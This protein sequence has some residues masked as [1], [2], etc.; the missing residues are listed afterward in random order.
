MSDGPDRVTFTWL[1]AGPGQRLPDI[2]A[3]GWKNKTASPCDLSKVFAVLAVDDEPDARDV[4]QT[5]LSGEGAVVTVAA[6]AGE[7][8]HQLQGEPLEPVLLADI[9]M[10]DEDGLALIQATGG[11][12]GRATTT[13]WIER[14]G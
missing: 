13:C 11:G 10:P 9:G 6:S 12:V 5:I 8:L 14:R 4:L 3:E 7:A 2:V 1:A